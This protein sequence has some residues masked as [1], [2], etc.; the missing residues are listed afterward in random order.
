[1]LEMEKFGGM[2][3]FLLEIM[4]IIFN[5]HWIAIQMPIFSSTLFSSVEEI[6]GVRVIIA[7]N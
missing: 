7:K 5:Y 4:H 3:N 2:S 1:M 6:G